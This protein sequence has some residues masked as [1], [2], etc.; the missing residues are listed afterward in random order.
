M[1]PRLHSRFHGLGDVMVNSIINLCYSTGAW[2]SFDLCWIPIYPTRPNVF[3]DIHYVK[4]FLSKL[5]PNL[6]ETFETWKN[7]GR[8][9]WVQLSSFGYCQWKNFDGINLGSWIWPNMMDKPYYTVWICFDIHPSV[10]NLQST[11]ALFFIL[12]HHSHSSAFNYFV[13][14]TYGDFGVFSVTIFRL[15]PFLDCKESCRTG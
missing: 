12:V 9:V 6:M 8:F 2:T 13:H 5:F 10:A 3:F 14:V 1:I 4:I 7:E 11:N 15:W